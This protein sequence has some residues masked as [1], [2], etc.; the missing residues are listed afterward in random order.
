MYGTTT[1]RGEGPNRGRTMKIWFQN[2]NHITHIDDRP[3][4]TSPDLIT[5]MDSKT[6]EPYTNTMVEKGMNIAVLGA[7]GAERYRTA[8]GLA[9]LG[10]R[11]FGYQM[12]YVPIEEHLDIK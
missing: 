11:H 6:G 7:K 1:I 10:P 4:V 3:F 5:V 12:D 2:E 8:P 9:I